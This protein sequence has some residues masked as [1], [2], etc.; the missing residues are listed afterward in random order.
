MKTLKTHPSQTRRPTFEVLYAMA[1]DLLEADPTIDD[2]EWRD[3]IK[4]ELVRRRYEYPWPPNALSAVMD[5][6][7]REFVKVHGPRPLH[8]PPAS[9]PLPPVAPDPATTWTVDMLARGRWFRD[10][11]LNT[12]RRIVARQTIDPPSS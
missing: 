3:Q 5:S 6:V 12:L 4:W 10:H 1:F 11:I 9:L 8:L 7:E 2:F